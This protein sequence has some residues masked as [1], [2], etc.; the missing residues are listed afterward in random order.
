MIAGVFRPVIFSFAPNG[1]SARVKGSK[2]TLV[3]N[4][5]RLV[6]H[7]VTPQEVPSHLYG[8]PLELLKHKG[9]K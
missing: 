6:E 9:R 4:W 7:M 8:K 5:T 2:T 3:A 1:I